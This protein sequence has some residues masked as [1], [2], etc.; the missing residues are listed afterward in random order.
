M[1]KNFRK[2]GNGGH[3]VLSWIRSFLA[4]IIC[5]A[6]IVML[7]PPIFVGFVILCVLSL[8]ICLIRFVM[9]KLWPLIDSTNVLSWIDRGIH[10]VYH[11]LPRPVAKAVSLL[12]RGM[13]FAVII[14]GACVL[15]VLGGVFAVFMCLNFLCDFLIYQLFGWDYEGA[16]EAAQERYWESLH[17]HH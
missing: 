13:A 9:D 1:K 3:I 10:H 16:C 7:I 6:V 14:P 2:F 15:F 11:R 12:V 5:A 4:R 8:L 17:P